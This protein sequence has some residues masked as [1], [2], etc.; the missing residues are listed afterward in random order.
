MHTPSTLQAVRE[1][2]QELS[3][4]DLLRGQTVD[5]VAARIDGT[6]DLAACVAGAVYV[7]EC[8][9]ESLELKRKV[10]GSLDAVCDEGTILASST[11]CL[12]PSTFTEGCECSLDTMNPH[13]DHHNLCITTPYD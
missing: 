4:N 8:T 10:F 3:D 11:S 12:A 7:Q 2:L 9:P 1:Q 5:E 13:N 6:D